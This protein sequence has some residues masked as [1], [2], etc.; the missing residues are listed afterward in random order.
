MATWRLE[1]GPVAAAPTSQLTQARERRLTFSLTEPST[2]QCSLD[3]RADEALDVL[4][5]ATDVHASRDGQVLYTGRVVATEDDF[6]DASHTVALSCTD[7][8]GLFA[9]RSIPRDTSWTNLDAGQVWRRLMVAATTFPNTDL[10]ITIPP[11]PATGVLLSREADAGA[12]ILAELQAAEGST[13]TGSIFDWDVAPGWGQ[14]EARIWAPQRGLDLTGL[15]GVVLDYTRRADVSGRVAPR[16]S[17]VASLRRSFDPSTYANVATISGGGSTVVAQREVTDPDTGAVT[18][19]AYSYKVPTRPISTR[20]GPAIVDVGTWSASESYPDIKTQAELDAFA[21][22][23]VEELGS[24]TP[25]YD[26]TLAD[27]WWGGPDHIWLGDTVR[28]IVDSG[29][30]R[31]DVALRVTAI[32]VNLGDDGQESVT[33]TVGPTRRT[34]LSTLLTHSRRLAL[35]ERTR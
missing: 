16:S 17:P 1:A 21:A 13:E 9:R 12:V 31:E 30:V 33:L 3:A 27:G 19:E 6:D 23:R 10:G 8:K 18:F 26:V 22:R 24:Y 4:D 29:R 15:G 35:L 5:L 32:D 20:D 7:I 25:T 11:A 2:L 34:S 14:R 28:L